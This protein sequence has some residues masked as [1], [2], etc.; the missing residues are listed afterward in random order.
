MAKTS[1]S[2]QEG[3]AFVIDESSMEMAWLLNQNLILT[4]GM[5]GLF[6]E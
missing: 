1:D 4:K 2:S 5:G 6:P 3:N